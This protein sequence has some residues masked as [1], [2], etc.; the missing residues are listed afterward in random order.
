MTRIID[1]PQYLGVIRQKSC[2]E[3]MSVRFSRTYGG[4]SHNQIEMV[5]LDAFSPYTGVIQWVMVRVSVQGQFPELTGFFLYEI[6]PQKR[7]DVFLVFTGVIR[8]AQRCLIVLFGCP[9]THGG[10]S[11]SE[12]D[13]V[14]T[15]DFSPYTRG[16]FGGINDITLNCTLFL[17]SEVFLG[18]TSRQL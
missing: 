1:C 5:K 10:Y 7:T 6:Q 18:N 11:G 12:T 17:C 8:L 15:G 4:Y 13:F 2:L 9:R 3:V 14:L 16:L